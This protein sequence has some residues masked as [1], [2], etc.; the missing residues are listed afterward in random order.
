M[1]VAP[2]PATSAPP[3]RRLGRRAAELLLLVLAAGVAGAAVIAVLTYLLSTL[4]GAGLAVLILVGAAVLAAGVGLLL[5]LLVDRRWDGEHWRQLATTGSGGALPIVL[6]S[7]GVAL[8]VECAGP[9]ASPVTVVFCHD[10]LLNSTYWREQRAALADQP[11]RQLYVD[12][13][14]H[15]ASGWR[16]PDPRIRGVGQ[17]ADD[18]RRV[19]DAAAPQGVLVLVG[20]GMGSMIIQELGAQCPE[21]FAERVRAVVLSCTSAGPLGPT[22]DLGMPGPLR[23]L[24]RRYAAASLV[25]LG[26]V[27]RRL[28]AAVC[29][30][31]PWLVSARVIGLD[32]YGYRELVRP[33]AAMAYSTSLSAAG[34]CLGAELEHDRREDVAALSEHATVTVI[35]GTTDRIIPL[36]EVRTLSELIPRSRYV[37]VAS[38]GHLV[39][40]EKPAE[41]NEQL[42]LTIRRACVAAGISQA[43]LRGEADVPLAARVIRGGV[44]IVNLGL[45]IGSN[46]LG[47]RPES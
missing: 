6:A 39:A 15:G 29:G 3:Q 28:I 8:H 18:L 26:T 42:L 7:D 33:A 45:S 25:L 1:A 36:T 38:A 43:Q 14:G 32:W 19:V 9:D 23:W 44:G 31:A 30:M 37:R 24:V 5:R 17:Y 41:I 40:L 34:H 46:I 21:L 13:R 12:L 2:V 4:V 27:P 16:R 11:Y 20:H 22:F 47:Q 10:V 35:S